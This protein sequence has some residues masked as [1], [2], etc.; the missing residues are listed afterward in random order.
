MIIPVLMTIGYYAVTV[1]GLGLLVA[2]HEAGHL[3]LARL[4]GMRVETYSIGFGPRLWGFQKG[5]TDYRISAFP[6][7]G[8]C[9]IAGIT[10]DDPAAQDPNDRGSYSN[11]PAWRRVLVIAAGPGV[12]YLAAFVILTLLYASGGVRDLTTTQIQVQPNGPAA[13]AGM[14]TGDRVLSIDG[15][16]VKSFYDLPPELAKP[17]AEKSIA[18]LRQGQT[19]TLL[20]HPASGRISVGPDRVTVPVPLGEV[21][22]RASHDVWAMAGQQV[23]GIANLFRHRGG[24]S[25]SG[26]LGIIKQASAEVAHGLGDFFYVLASIS[27]GLCVFNFLPVP[28]LDGGRLIFLGIELTSG[29]KVNPKAE[30]VV[31]LVGLLLLLGLVLGVTIL[32]DLQLGKKLFHWS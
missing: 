25:L 12:N 18:V 29:R 23:S 1:L 3:A 24:A 28:A 22:P 14:L 19:V 27:V 2:A 8:Y 31:H 11:K 6:L 17:G 21:I 32:G 5:D 7:G 15:V 26:P 20:V 4:M 9:K 13:M 30:T 10:P 16:P